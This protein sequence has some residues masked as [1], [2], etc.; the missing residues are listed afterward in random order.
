VQPV[1]GKIYGKENKMIP[2]PSFTNVQNVANSEFT[3]FRVRAVRDSWFTR[4]LRKNNI[5]RSFDDDRAVRLQT[6]HFAGIQ[7]IRVDQIVG[8]VGRDVDFDKNFRPL[9]KHLRDRWVNALLRLNSDGWQ[10]IVVHKLDESYYVEDG[11]HRVSVAHFVGMLFIEAEVWDHTF[12]QP[13]RNSCEP[14]HGIARMKRE[15]YSI[16]T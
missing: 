5:P 6:R 16:N 14:K 3:R 12:C 9:K 11:H 4:I 8:T 7:T 10:P 15:V 1:A 13:P 2:S